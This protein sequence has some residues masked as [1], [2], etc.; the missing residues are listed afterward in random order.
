[1]ERKFFWL[2]L[3]WT[4]VITVASLVSVNSFSKIKSVGNDKI[5]HFLFYLFFVILWGLVKR[6]N[7]SNRKYYLFVF[8]VAM[9][10]GLIIE[11]LQEI[12]T[13]TR[14]ADFYDFL[15]N[16]IGAFVGLIVLL[17]YK[18]KFF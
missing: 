15:A 2:A 13:N 4:F 9:S 14:Q 10:Y 8:L 6:Q 12:L 1:M 11:V 7:D 18:N 5:V 3:I 16:T 17:Y